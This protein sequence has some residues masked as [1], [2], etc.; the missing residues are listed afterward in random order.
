MLNATKHLKRDLN[1]RRKKMRGK[2]ATGSSTE[3]GS[4]SGSNIS[5]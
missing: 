2:N 4:S 5:L 3:S 1:L